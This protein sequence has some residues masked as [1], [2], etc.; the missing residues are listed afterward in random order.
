MRRVKPNEL[1]NSFR[2]VSDT[3]EAM[4]F[5]LNYA[6]S[7]LVCANVSQCRNDPDAAKDCATNHNWKWRGV[8]DEAAA[9]RRWEWEY[10]FKGGRNEETGKHTARVED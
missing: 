5:D 1:I 3:M 7:C 9:S 8:N 6:Q 2:D 4:W 10:I